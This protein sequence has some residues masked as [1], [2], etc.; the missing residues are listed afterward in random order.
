MNR[1]TTITNYT[2]EFPT[3]WDI[4]G[5]STSG[6]LCPEKIT[7]VVKAFPLPGKYRNKKTFKRVKIGYAGRFVEDPA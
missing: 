1:V 3:F 4:S 6:V 2:A 5:F 7:F